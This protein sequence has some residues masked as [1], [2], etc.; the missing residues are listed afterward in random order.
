[1]CGNQGQNRTQQQENAEANRAEENH[2]HG[3]LRSC[4][5]VEKME[6]KTGQQGAAGR[7]LGE[8]EKTNTP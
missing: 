6:R 4:A 1:L 3:K 2:E 7:N 8:R 5:R